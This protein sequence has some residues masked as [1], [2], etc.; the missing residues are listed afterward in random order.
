MPALQ[1]SFEGNLV[2][3]VKK[4]TDPVEEIDGHRILVDRLWPRG[5][6]KEDVVFEE[7]IKEIAPST[8]L[9]QWFGHDPSKWE[10]FREMYWKELDAKQEHL[11]RLLFFVKRG[12]VTLLFG[13]K[14]RNHNNA[15]ALKEYLENLMVN[16]QNNRPKQVIVKK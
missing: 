8:T 10:E 1:I 4:V 14:E 3:R 7:W 13:S 16:K 15:V 9:R 2:I 11:N 6:K 12:D 5:V